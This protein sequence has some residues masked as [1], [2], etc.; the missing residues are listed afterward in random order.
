MSHP[1]HE[2]VFWACGHVAQDCRC[3]APDKPTRTKAKK[4]PACRTAEEVAT[5]TFCP[6]CG[7]RIKHNATQD[8][9]LQP[10]APVNNIRPPT[11]LPLKDIREGQIIKKPEW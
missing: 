1:G 6:H 7:A 3:A 2:R 5:P 10:M 9:R 11:P 8:G 4:C